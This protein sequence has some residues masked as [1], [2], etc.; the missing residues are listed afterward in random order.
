[1]CHVVSLSLK[2]GPKFGGHEFKF[3]R[4]DYIA[5]SPTNASHPSCIHFKHTFNEPTIFVT[6]SFRRGSSYPLT[7]TSISCSCASRSTT[8]SPPLPATHLHLHL[9]WD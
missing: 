1:M 9:C 8:G 6:F 7:I 5:I 4:E 3:V 2:N